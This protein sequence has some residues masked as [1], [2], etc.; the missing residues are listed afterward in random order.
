MVTCRTK[1]MDI[2]VRDGEWAV[3]AKVECKTG[4][5]GTETKRNDIGIFRK[6]EQL[7]R[8]SLCQG[9]NLDLLPAPPA[10]A[11]PFHDCVSDGSWHRLDLCLKLRRS[12]LDN[13]DFAS[14][15]TRCV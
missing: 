3:G 12:R 8:E 15:R 2:S 4:E 10:L 6:V 13:L 11:L 1:S 9:R 14:R 5:K 7:R